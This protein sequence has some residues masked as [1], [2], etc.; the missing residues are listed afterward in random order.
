MS[1]GK[2]ATESASAITVMHLITGL[3]VGGA[4]A[5]LCKLLATSRDNHFRHI[6]VSLMDEGP[7][8]KKVKAN[9]VPLYSLG[10]QQ[11]RPR[12]ASVLHFLRLVSRISP[13]VLQTWLYHAD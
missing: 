8:G 12:L 9:K 5:M 13:D 2:I 6:V 7:L 10:M 11:G 3:N 1:R 4:E